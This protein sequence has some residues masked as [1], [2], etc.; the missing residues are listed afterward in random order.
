MIVQ[1]PP[2]DAELSDH[3]AHLR[4]VREARGLSL[5]ALAD[6]ANLSP[7]TLSLAEHG[8]LRL[9]SSQHFALETAL[10]VPLGML[11]SHDADLSRLRRL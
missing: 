10:H 2:V 4:A 1:L 3:G 5:E 7:A 11:F 6:A 8:R 9:T